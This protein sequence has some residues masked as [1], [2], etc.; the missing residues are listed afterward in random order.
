MRIVAESIY[1][2]LVFGVCAQIKI[3]WMC[4]KP[5]E[6]VLFNAPQRIWREQW[7]RLHNI[8]AGLFYIVLEWAMFAHLGRKL[9]RIEY[10]AVDKSAERANK[11]DDNSD[12]KSRIY[13]VNEI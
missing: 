1:T 2:F 7:K 6:L 9:N 12:E 3:G 13:S 5:S 8:Y 4:L 11:K 10:K